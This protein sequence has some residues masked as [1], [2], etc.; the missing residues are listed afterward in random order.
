MPVNIDKVVVLPAP[1][2]PKRAKIYPLYIVIFIPLTAT[3]VPNLLIRP[4]IFKHSLFASYLF[5]ESGIT[6]KFFY[7]LFPTS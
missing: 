1:L 2:W 5:K 7:F 6:S 3:L 4:L